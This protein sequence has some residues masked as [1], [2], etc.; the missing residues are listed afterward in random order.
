M[1]ERPL[2]I[3]LCLL[4]PENA[5]KRLRVDGPSFVI[6]RHDECNLQLQSSLLSRRH[7]EIIIDDVARSVSIRDLG[8]R[9]GT[10]VNNQKLDANEPVSLFHHDVLRI[11]RLSFRL[12]IKDSVTEERHRNPQSASKDRLS[13]LLSELDDMTHDTT[14]ET[15]VKATGILAIPTEQSKQ[16]RQDFST[17]VAGPSEASVDQNMETIPI[18]EMDTVPVDNPADTAGASEVDETESDQSGSKEYVKKEPMKLP[19]Q[20]RH[21]PVD[22]QEAATEALKRHFSRGF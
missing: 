4:D 19:K 17:V 15:I 5:G 22:S 6:G 8:S 13:S 11:G 1:P 12:S 14:L 2:K 18:I 16:A 9:N 3:R 10:F 21:L 20:L 7:C